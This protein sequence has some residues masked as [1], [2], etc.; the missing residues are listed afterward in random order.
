[1]KICI[2]GRA[3]YSLLQRRAQA[4][5]AEGHDVHVIS[6]E[7]G[8]IAGCTVH[9]VRDYRFARGLRYALAAP[10][11]LREFRRIAPDIVDIHGVSS[12]GLY[13]LLALNCPV[14]ATIYGPDIYG[15][16]RL[17]SLLR[18]GI[19]AVL[20]RSDIVYGSTPAVGDYIRDVLGLELGQRLIT[21]SWGIAVDQIMSKA[22]QR[23]H[24]L[25]TELGFESESRVLV[26]ARH[27]VPL[28]RPETILEAMPEVL[29]EESQ[30]QLVF[31]YPKPNT[32]GEALLL[33]MRTR[34]K[35]LGLQNH[36]RF[37]GE[38]PY[39]RFI[40]FLHASDLFVCIG[41]HDLLASTLL[42]AMATGLVPILSDLQAYHEVINDGTNGYLIPDPTPS[43]VA[44]TI[45]RVLQDFN[46]LHPDIAARNETLVRE[47]Y[48]ER[49][50]TRRLLGQFENLLSR[51]QAAAGL[52]GR[53]GSTLHGHYG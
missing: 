46:A 21:H 5:V 44:Q 24:Q 50:C 28:W 11:V 49:A 18:R 51:K 33:R 16:A 39:E 2:L 32:E 47:R 30:A 23:R 10:L 48:D 27:L 8:A 25:R 41:T 45:S 36:V 40:S 22:A 3:N 35:E 12:Y 37:I 52:G 38:Q 4:Y 14:V 26:H 7:E 1:M 19:T 13:A 53:S 34:V 42:E 17:S 29:K 6:L 20:K 31:L 43:S 9:V 15:P